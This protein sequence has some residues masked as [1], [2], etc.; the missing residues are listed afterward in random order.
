MNED[1][2]AEWLVKRKNPAYRVPAIILMVVLAIASLVLMTK[3]SWAFLLFVTVIFGSAYFIRFLKVEYE[4]VF[5]TNELD[6]DLI[7]SQ[8]IRKTKVKVEMSNVEYVEPTNEE[9]NRIAKENGELKY[10]DYTSHEK[11][12]PKSYTIR[13]SLNG[14]SHLLVFEPNEKL[15]RAMWR[16]SPQKVHLEK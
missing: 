15:L 12:A 3:S 4:Y 11:D 8:Q 6:I 9:K 14:E 13:Y 5:V 10:E 1:I 2:Y 16:C 7:Y